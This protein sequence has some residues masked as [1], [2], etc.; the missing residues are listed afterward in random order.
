MVGMK[1]DGLTSR[2][3]KM[4]LGI[5]TVQCTCYLIIKINVC[6]TIIMN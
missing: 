1:N 3:I 6:R 2:E 4:C 5:Y